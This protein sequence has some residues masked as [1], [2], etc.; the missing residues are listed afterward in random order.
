MNDKVQ[1]INGRKSKNAKELLEELM[2]MADNGEI[3][4]IGFYAVR[5]NQTSYCD[6]CSDTI[7]NLDVLAGGLGRAAYRIYEHTEV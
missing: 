1:S 5:N 6:W 7:M 2:A 3:L 4:A